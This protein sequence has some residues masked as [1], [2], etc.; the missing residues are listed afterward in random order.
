MIFTLFATRATVL[1][2]HGLGWNRNYSATCSREGWVF[3]I[4]EPPTAGRVQM[5][6]LHATEAVRGPPVAVTSRRRA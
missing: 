4:T 6:R 5:L 3:E 2:I 1:L